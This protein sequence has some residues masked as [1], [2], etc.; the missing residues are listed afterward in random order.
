MAEREGAPKLP[1]T[2][3]SLGLVSLANDTA[4][5]MIY[6]LL[7]AFL[8]ATLGAGPAAIGVVE[9]IAEATAALGKGLF[10][11]L[12]DRW[13]KNKGFVVAGYAISTAVRP[14][15][16]LA[17]TWPVVAA[18]RF[19]D[20]VGKGIRSAPRDRMVAAA[21]PAGRRGKA[22][23]F[24]R[25]MD[26]IGALAGPIAATLLLRFAGLDIRTVFALTLVPGLATV[27]ILIFATPE[28]AAR[29]ASQ[30][31]GEK[32]GPLPR[33]LKAVIASVILFSLANSTDAFLLL[34]AKECGVAVWA[35]PLLWA[36]FNG[37][38]AAANTPL[39][40]LADRFGAGRTL[41]TGWILYA[42][43]YFA[44]GR[45]TGIVTVVAV[46]F[47]YALYYAFA[48]GAERALVADLAPARSRG[49]AFGAFYMTS[50]LAALPASL[51]FGA[52]WSRV[53]RPRGFRHGRGLRT[54]GFRRPGSCTPIPADVTGSRNL[55]FRV[56]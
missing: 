24:E 3:V 15:I 31:S 2:V 18:I 17:G 44:F 49:R 39:G 42:I 55:F 50:G 51:L 33:E 25:A 46:F 27:A 28:K 5:E 34:R 40:A 43:S 21:V 36:A 54:S 11:W 6:P 45:V 52:I 13:P 7:P 35:L 30:P 10:G 47:S 1:R 41:V 19:A 32:A 20:R 22:F 8:A 4:S 38:R 16:A 23:G 14:L 37:V 12:S 53:R 29:P 56:A 26:N 9:G 48:E